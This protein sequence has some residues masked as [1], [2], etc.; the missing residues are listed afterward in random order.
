MP[1]QFTTILNF[2]DVGETVNSQTKSSRLSTQRFYRSARPDN[3]SSAD[4][5]ALKTAVSIKTII[6]LRTTT[7]HMQQSS[8]RDALIKA[9]SSALAP[10]TEDDVSQ[11]VQIPGIDYVLISFTGSAYSRHLMG[12][13]SWRNTIK[14]IALMAIGKRMEAISILGTNVMRPTGLAGLA[15]ASVD[16]CGKEV[17]E[18]FEVLEDAGALPCV[19]SLHSGER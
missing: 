1:H 14:L 7:E 13:L 16:V 2:R 6:D 8:K 17:K 4:R 18:V 19:N 12:Q 11:P 10:K 15:I 9:Q 3:A 5:E